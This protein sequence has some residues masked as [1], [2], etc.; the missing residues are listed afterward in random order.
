MAHQLSSNSSRLKRVEMEEYGLYLEMLRSTIS[1][2][3]ISSKETHQKLWMIKNHKYQKT[4][5]QFSASFKL[6]DMNMSF[7]IEDRFTNSE[8]EKKSL[9]TILE[10]Y[11]LETL[12]SELRTG[13]LRISSANSAKSNMLEWVETIQV[14]QEDLLTLDTKTSEVP[15]RHRLNSKD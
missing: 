3:L 1:F 8:K 10:L 6:R 4:V 12:T 15:K 7:I 9:K 2:S 5:K 14:D 11:T 13:K